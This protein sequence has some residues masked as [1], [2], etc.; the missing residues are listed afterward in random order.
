MAYLRFQ[1]I[2]NG[3]VPIRHCN[4]IF[5]NG[6]IYDGMDP[7]IHFRS[8]VVDFV[9]NVGFLFTNLRKDVCNFDGN[10]WWILAVSLV[11]CVG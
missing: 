4:S 2:Y 5:R 3:I 10:V 8:S 11:R 7:I 1:Q 6:Q 9:R